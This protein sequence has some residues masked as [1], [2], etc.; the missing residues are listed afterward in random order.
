[1]KLLNINVDQEKKIFGILE[2]IQLQ[3]RQSKHCLSRQRN[4]EFFGLGWALP[5]WDNGYLD[6]WKKIPFDLKLNRKFYKDTLIQK[7]ICKVWKGKKW[8]NLN[9]NIK[10]NPWYLR[11]LRFF[12]KTFFIFSKRKWKLFDKKYF[13]YWIDNFCGYS[14]VKYYEV[15]KIQNEFRGSLSWQ[16]LT[17][18]KNIKTSNSETL[19]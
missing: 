12:A 4:Y 11:F 1:M 13:F 8:I 14:H 2:N 19:K 16:T 7:D 9:S 6:F 5:L 15:L 10:I 17:Y 3:E 18:V